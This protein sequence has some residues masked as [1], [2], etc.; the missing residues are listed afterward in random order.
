MEG[1]QMFAGALK[2]PENKTEL[3]SIVG[4]Y[5]EALGREITGQEHWALST[6]LNGA[7][8]TQ[9][10]INDAYEMIDKMLEE[11]KEKGG[12]NPDTGRQFE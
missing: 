12:N 4:S 11:I 2:T 9:D 8:N 3:E 7:T 6:R 1:E 10:S 5:E